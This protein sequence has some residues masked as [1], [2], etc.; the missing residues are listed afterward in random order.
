M[1]RRGLAGSARRAG[2]SEERLGC[3]LNEAGF[4]KGYCVERGLQ[5]FQI[6]GALPKSRTITTCC[7]SG[8]GRSARYLAKTL[9]ISL[10]GVSL[11]PAAR[12]RNQLTQAATSRLVRGAVA[13]GPNHQR[14]APVHRV[15]R[16][17]AHPGSAGLLGQPHMGLLH[18]A[19]DSY[20]LR[21][22]LS[23]LTLLYR[24]VD[25]KSL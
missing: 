15:A 9:F 20:T 23:M 4:E 18:P 3:V 22:H 14:R 25:T 8:S 16:A 13:G 10:I 24:G 7:Y 17:N 6:D 1:Q 11:K 19:Y 12:C 5:Q 2:E 21:V